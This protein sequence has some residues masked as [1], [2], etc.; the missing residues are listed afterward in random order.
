MVSIVVW[1]ALAI[2]AILVLRQLT[3]TNKLKV[4]VNAS[5]SV[6]GILGSMRTLTR[7]YQST[8]WLVGGYLQTVY[9]MRFRKR[10]PLVPRRLE[11]RLFDDGTL[12]L[13]FFEPA[14]SDGSPFVIIIPTLGGSTREPCVNNLAETFYRRG[15]RSVVMNGRGFAGLQFRTERVGC[16][17]D[18][19]D[20]RDTVQ[21]LLNEFHPPALFVAGFSLGSMQAMSYAWQNGNNVDGIAVMSHMY[22]VLEGAKMLERPIQRRL[23]APV[24]MQGLRRTVEKY[25]FATPE[26]KA[27]LRKCKTMREF[28]HL[29]T[30]RCRGY[31]GH[32]EYYAAA[33]IYDKIPQVKVPTLLL[34]ADNDPFARAQD[35]P[36]KEARASDKV[37]FVHVKDGGHVAF[38]IG[39]DAK[40]S[41]TEI[42]VPDW[43]DAILSSRHK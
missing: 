21:Y 39:W 10:S 37:V 1:A 11:L 25:Q 2:L 43:F 38:P 4:E 18:Q 40:R 36:V 24:I 29:F 8:P 3:R 33:T 17:I 22:N 31:P 35:G 23:F 32:V 15:W 9:G 16:A 20:V 42:I 13:D 7:S 5:G 6:S 12:A 27:E 14:D 26:R 19:E 30:A 28:D 41:L 34:S